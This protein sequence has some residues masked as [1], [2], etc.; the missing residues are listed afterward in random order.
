VIQ[1]KAG[2]EDALRRIELYCNNHEKK[3]WLKQIEE[4]QEVVNAP[5]PKVGDRLPIQEMKTTAGLL[6]VLGA[7]G[8]GI[9][10][11]WQWIAA[12]R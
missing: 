11:A 3:P 5:N 2:L 6:N 1:K 9:R 12:P 7:I 10:S 8:T 4:W